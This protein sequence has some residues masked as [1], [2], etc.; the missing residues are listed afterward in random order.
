ME[1]MELHAVFVYIGIMSAARNHAFRERQSLALNSAVAARLS[2]QPAPVMERAAQTLAR[3][4]LIPGTWCID[5]AKWEEIVARA[6]VSE[7]HR[8]L[9]GADETSIRLRQSS[10]FSVQLEPKQRLKILRESFAA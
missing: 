9:T 3:W 6:D 8:L 7:I 5:L 1:Y 2:T 10:P 4:K